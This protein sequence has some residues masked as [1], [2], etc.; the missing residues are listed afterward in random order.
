LQLHTSDFEIVQ[1]I[2]QVVQIDKS[3]ETVSPML[4]LQF[5]RAIFS[6]A[7]SHESREF[8]TVVQ[9]YFQIE[10]CSILCNSVD[11]ILNADWSVVIDVFVL[12]LFAV[13]IRLFA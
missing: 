11:R 7:F 13:Y 10:L 5:S 4:R 8:L 6:C 2:L 1:R 3:C 9:L 12:L